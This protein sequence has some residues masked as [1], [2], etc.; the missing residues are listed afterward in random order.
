M[1]TWW[2]GLSPRERLLVGVGVAVAAALLALQLFI[3]PLL[4]WRRDAG[5]RE[6]AAARAYQLVS[7]AAAMAPASAGTS[8][9]LETPVRNALTEAAA[10]R[11]VG[12]TFVN[13]QTDGS[14]SLQA[15]PA[16][17]DAV[18]EMFGDLERRYAIRVV[19]A[20]IARSPENPGLLRL[21]ATLAR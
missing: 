14:V 17:P 12:L 16:S 21:Q 1:K 8:A 20:D 11:Q 7:R 6:Q 3:A 5:L 2:N 9:D 15:G 4:D 18:Y 19:S 10:R 13:A